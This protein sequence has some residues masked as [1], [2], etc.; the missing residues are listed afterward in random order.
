MRNAKR[1]CLITHRRLRI[2]SSGIHNVQ[3]RKCLSRFSDEA[4]VFGILQSRPKGPRP[5]VGG[6]GG[7]YDHGPDLS[8]AFF[9]MS[10]MG[11]YIPQTAGGS[12]SENR[13]DPRPTA[14]RLI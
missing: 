9:D 12:I 11:S 4:K 8:N 6:G 3:Q 14:G 7:L 5:G 13:H 1:T 10:G 2:P